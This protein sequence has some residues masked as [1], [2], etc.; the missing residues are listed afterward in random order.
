L[1]DE[2]VDEEKYH[3]Y[4]TFLEDDEWDEDDC[5]FVPANH[6]LYVRYTSGAS[7]P[8]KG[9]VRDHGGTA[10]ALNYAMKNIFNV[11]EESVHFSACHHAWD[12]GHNFLVYGPLLRCAKTVIWEGDALYPDPGVLW[13]VVE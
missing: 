10:V 13:A 6:P 9:I 2:D 8:S 4:K 11:T 3:D 7:G 5:D 12:I 1:F